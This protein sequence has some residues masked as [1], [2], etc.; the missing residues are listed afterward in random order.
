MQTS[1][2]PD[3]LRRWRSA[4]RVSQTDLAA[5]AEVSARHISFL[6]TGRARPSRDMVLILASALEVPLR[7]RNE[8]LAAA[9]FAGAY[10]I[11]SVDADQLG[12]VRR[13]V[14]WALRQQEPYPAVVLNRRWDVV[15]TNGPAERLFTWLLDEPPVGTPNL[16]RTMFDP[17][18]A[19]RWVANWD[20]VAPALIARV[21]REA[22]GGVLDP[23]TRALVDELRPLA[24]REPTRVEELPVVP[25]HFRRDQRSFRFFSAVLTLGTP[26]DITAEELRIEC[27]YPED[28][29]T[30]RSAR[31][32][33]V[34]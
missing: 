20:R 13:A 11:R 17:T 24:P 22:V 23:E 29:E 21:H 2:F 25:I 9:G 6:E 5:D 12:P 10:P 8:L 3:L 34:G 27:F 1:S 7:E 18:G 31:R 19:R 14:D 28:P 26:R 30:E 32:W 15:R 16:L 33:L 4:R